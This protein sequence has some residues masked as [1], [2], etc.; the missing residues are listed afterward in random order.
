M[1]FMKIK[2]YVGLTVMLAMIALGH[3]SV[4]L[5]VSKGDL[6]LAPVLPAGCEQLALPDGHRVAHRVYALGVQIYRWNGMAWSFVGPEAN[7]YADE[8]FHGKIGT[9]YS[10]PTWETNSGSFV[11]ADPSS[12]IPCTP[13]PNGVA[14]LRLTAANSRGP[15]I[16]SGVTYIHRLN[17]SGGLRP[18]LPG[19]FVDEIKRVPYTTEYYFY[20]AEY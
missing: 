6:P 14:W 11:I 5:A 2:Q 15:G 19:V 3:G 13:D 8:A 20:K 9:H 16:L 17:T 12:A 4:T 1:K 18:T 10:G 7:L